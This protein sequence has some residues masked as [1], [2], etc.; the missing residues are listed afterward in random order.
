[1]VVCIPGDSF[2]SPG[3]TIRSAAS[4]LLGTLRSNSTGLCFFFV[5]STMVV[6]IVSQIPELIIV[7][8]PRVLYQKVIQYMEPMSIHVQSC[9][10]AENQSVALGVV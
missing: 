2:G 6:A 9:S 4:T 1:M 5:V 10:W 7:D 8:W 3:L